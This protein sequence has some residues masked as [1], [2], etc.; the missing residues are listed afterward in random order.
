MFLRK[1]LALRGPNVWAN[2]PVL[3]VWAELGSLKDSLSHSLPG[4]EDRLLSWLPSLGEHHCSVGEPGG[5]VQWLRRGTH[6]AH[7]LEHVTLELQ[8]LAGTEVSFSRTQETA[9]PGS[10]R[11]AIE[12]EYE[13]LGK[14]A[15]EVARR[16][17]LAAVNGQAFDVAVEVEK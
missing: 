16:L 9:E 11:L 6:Q 17:C 15:V 4:F 13:D 7:V 1:V 3:E 5:F 8:C 14:A 2:F 12:Y 10:Y